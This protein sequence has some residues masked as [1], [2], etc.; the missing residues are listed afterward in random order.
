MCP[1]WS[2]LHNG[3]HTD[4][5]NGSESTTDSLES[6]NGTEISFNDT[7]GINCSFDELQ[8]A[9]NSIRSK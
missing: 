7:L 4:A 5:H 1:P 6:D 8:M 9:A 3:N 2:H